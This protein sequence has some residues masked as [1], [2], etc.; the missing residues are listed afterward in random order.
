MSDSE[1]KE[2]CSN[3]T[4]KIPKMKYGFL[5]SAYFLMMKHFAYMGH[6]ITN[7]RYVFPGFT[8]K[9]LHILTD[10]YSKNIMSIHNFMKT[11]EGNIM[12]EDYKTVLK[13]AKKNDFVFLDPPY[14]EAHD[15]QFSYNHNQKLK[16]SFLKELKNELSKLDKRCV[17]W[18]M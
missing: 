15:Y 2:Y 9:A 17:K 3:I 1:K 6:I 13:L 18:M 11:T 8:N 10:K 14:I 4:K 7:N 12:N 5:R 16:S